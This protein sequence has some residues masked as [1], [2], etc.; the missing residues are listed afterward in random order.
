MAGVAL[1]A[2]QCIGLFLSF[3]V[4]FVCLFLAFACFYLVLLL[5]QGDGDRQGG[6][7]AART[8]R[9]RE[10]IRHV[11]DEPEKMFQINLKQA[12]Q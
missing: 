5:Q 7:W 4:A 12:M 3:F 9:R 6:A 8:K 10:S 11:P 1:I 2:L